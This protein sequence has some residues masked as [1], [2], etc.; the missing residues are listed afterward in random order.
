ML[1]TTGKPVETKATSSTTT[2]SKDTPK[3]S[4]SDIV[5]DE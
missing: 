4:P 5:D 2:Q 3:T 1:P